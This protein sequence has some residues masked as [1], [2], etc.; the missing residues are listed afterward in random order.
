[1]NW[2]VKQLPTP[3]PC[4]GHDSTPNL[5]IGGRSYSWETDIV[6]PFELMVTI[7]ATSTSIWACC[8]WTT[9]PNIQRRHVMPSYPRSWINVVRTLTPGPL[10]Q[11]AA[12]ASPTQALCSSSA[13]V[14]AQDTACLTA[15]APLS[16]SQPGPSTWSQRNGTRSSLSDPTSSRPLLTQTSVFHVPCQSFRP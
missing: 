11:A 9:S 13:S 5:V 15:P 1:M 10:A 8:L 2:E 14:T 12:R 6:I 7:C 4:D 3:V 16:T